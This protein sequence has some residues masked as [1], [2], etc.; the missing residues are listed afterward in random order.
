MATLEPEKLS[1]LVTSD[2]VRKAVKES[3]IQEVIQRINA[4]DVPEERAKALQDALTSMPD[5][6]K[7]CDELLRTVGFTD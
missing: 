4:L 6:R 2:T 1:L 3:W 5:F 7:F